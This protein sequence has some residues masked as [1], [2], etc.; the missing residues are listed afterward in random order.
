[1]EDGLDLLG[2]G[3]RLFFEGLGNELEPALRDLAQQMEPAL[4]ELMALIEDF[5]AYQMPEKLPNGDII[6]RRKPDLPPQDI[7]QPGP[8]GEIEL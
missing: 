4:R 8:G 7:P 2:Q 5:D 6:I 1:M 3:M